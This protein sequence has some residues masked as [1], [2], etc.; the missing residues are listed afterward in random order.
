MFQCNWFSLKSYFFNFMYLK[1]FSE[2]I[3]FFYDTMCSCTD[4]LT[5]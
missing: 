1:R 4:P 3:D 2:E 5:N